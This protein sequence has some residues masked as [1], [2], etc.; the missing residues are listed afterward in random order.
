MGVKR[1]SPLSSQ[2]GSAVVRS[3]RVSKPRATC[4]LG[5]FGFTAKVVRLL[6]AGLVSFNQTL[7]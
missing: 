3:P 2:V 5:E 7:S 4:P 6:S 1:K